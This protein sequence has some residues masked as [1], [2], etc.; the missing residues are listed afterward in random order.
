MSSTAER[1][2]EHDVVVSRISLSAR[3]QLAGLV[4]LSVVVYALLA[5]LRSVPT[6][7]PDEYL[8]SALG[9]SLA[10]GHGPS[11][12]GAPAH[13]PAL[14][15]PLLTAPAWWLPHVEQSLRAIQVVNAV[16]VSLA[17]VPAYVL[18]RRV[19]LTH[20]TALSIAVLTLVA[21]Q[22]TLSSQVLSEPIA[23]PLALAAIASAVA[24]VDRPSGRA[25]AVFLAFAL[26]ATLA[27][28]QLAVIPACALVAV[29]PVGARGDGIRAALRR[30]RVL[31]GVV[32]LQL[33]GGVA[34]AASGSVGYYATLLPSRAAF[35]GSWKLAPVDVYVL[36]LSA[37][38]VIVP[39]ALVGGALALVRPRVRAELAFATVSAVFFG[40]LVLEA[41]FFGDVKLVQERYLFYAVPLLGIAF[42]LRMTRTQRR[43]HAEAAVAAAFAAFAALVPLAGYVAAQTSPA[44]L[45]GAVRRLELA[46]GNQGSGSLV[47]AVAATAAVALGIAAVARRRGVQT[48]ALAASALVAVAIA[49]GALSYERL[50]NSI[51]RASLPAD[52]TWIDDAHA[53]HPAFVASPGSARDTILETLFWNRSV[54]RVYLLPGAQAP[55]KFAAPAVDVDAAGTLLHDGRPVTQAVVLDDSATTTRLAD[56]RRLAAGGPVSLWQPNGAAR[57]SLLMWGRLDDGILLNGGGIWLWPKTTHEG[58]VELRLTTVSAVKPGTFTLYDHHR[59]VATRELPAGRVTTLRVPLCDAGRFARGF[60]SNN[61]V[62]AVPRYVPDPGACSRPTL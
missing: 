49:A 5:R 30:H 23:Y 17:A 39:A 40:A 29:V 51:V 42:G 56:A 35:L 22:L 9:R 7:F 32:A 47:F 26:L 59:P 1:V 58:W 57:L 19:R 48:A 53:G 60:T 24:L 44:P 28:V 4:A 37:G 38:V 50:T 15:E 27:R 62:A 18:A 13:F 46:V 8:Y 31:A 2:G 55:D 52:L 21:P 41:C 11:V 10:A 33:L 43:W 61:A 36:F 14:L 20:G 16:A 12:R 6:A 45:Q 54:G 25:T 3:A 34:V